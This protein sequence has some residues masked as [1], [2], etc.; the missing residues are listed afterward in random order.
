MLNVYEFETNNW[1]VFYLGLIVENQ[2]VIKI[3][4]GFDEINYAKMKGITKT[5]R[6]TDK[7]I[8]SP[9]DDLEFKKITDTYFKDLLYL[10]KIE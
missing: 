10:K 8:L 7:Y 6:T 2:L 9:K 3:G 4:F 1:A 5:E